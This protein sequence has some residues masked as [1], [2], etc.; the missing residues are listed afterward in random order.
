MRIPERAPQLP[1][2]FPL[3]TFL[4]GSLLKRFPEVYV[5]FRGAFKVL[6]CALCV[7]E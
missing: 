7:S 2:L 4:T 1:S 5:P 3:F 6:I